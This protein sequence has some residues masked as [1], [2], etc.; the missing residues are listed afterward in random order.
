[1]NSLENFNSKVKQAAKENLKELD[2]LILFMYI[3][4]SSQNIKEDLLK[5]STTMYQRIFL[6]DNY[7]SGD[8]YERNI[9]DDL[10]NLLSLAYYKGTYFKLSTSE[11]LKPSFIKIS[12]LEGII[13]VI[14]D[15][16]VI[17]TFKEIMYES[18]RI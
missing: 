11:H 18:R 17:E 14:G 9:E 8:T 3:E 10:K 16:Q 4:S 15:T 1:M 6:L 7:L 12:I 2:T 13:D 5:Y